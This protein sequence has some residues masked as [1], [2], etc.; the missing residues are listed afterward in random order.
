MEIQLPSPRLETTAPIRI[1]CYLPLRSIGMSSIGVSYIGLSVCR[2]SVYRLLSGILCRFLL[3]FTGECYSPLHKNKRALPEYPP[4]SFIIPYNREPGTSFRFRK[5]WPPPRKV[6]LTI[7]HEPL[8]INHHFTNAPCA[9]Y[10]FSPRRMK[11]WPS[12]RNLTALAL[13]LALSMP[14]SFSVAVNCAV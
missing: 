12:R 8:T 11:I 13:A 6:I 7:N 1:K 5:E 14:C 10:T 3:C 2:L 9:L 4:A